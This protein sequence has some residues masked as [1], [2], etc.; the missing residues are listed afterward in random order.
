MNRLLLDIEPDGRTTVLVC[1][2]AGLPRSVGEP[3]RLVSPLTPADLEDLRWYLEDYLEIPVAGFE[4]R[5]SDIVARLLHWGQA[6]FQL[7]FGAGPARDAY[8]R[9]RERGAV[10]IVVR[11]LSPGWLGLPWELMT[12]P[13]RSTPLVLDGV[14]LSRSLPGADCDIALPV[15]GPRLRVLMVISRPAGSADVAYRMIAL[16]LLSRLV[17]VPGRVELVVLRP[18]TL[19]ALHSA[20]LA[21]RDAGRPFQ[22]VH[23][24]G[25]GALTGS[26]AE[27]PNVFASP[28]FGG[29]LLFEKPQG[30][31]DAVSADRL[32]HVLKEARVRVVVLNACE[33]G[34]VGREVEAA[35]ATRLL[36]D[37][38]AAVVA[39]AYSVYTKAAA[40]FM[41]AFYERLFAGDAVGEAVR[42]GR[43]RMASWPDRPCVVGDLPLKDWMVPVHYLR[44]EVRFPDLVTEVVPSRLSVEEV[45]DRLEART[46]GDRGDALVSGEE[47]VDRDVMIY[48]LEAA[49]RASPVVVLHGQGGAGKTELAKAFGRWWRDTAGVEKPEWVF[50]HSFE[51]GEHKLAAVLDPVGVEV[52]GPA[53]HSNDEAT[54]CALVV[55][56]LTRHRVLLI[57]DNFEVVAS[58]PAEEAGI[59]DERRAEFTEFLTRVHTGAGMV[60]IT[61]RSPEP[62]LPRAHRENLRG[63]TTSETAEYVNK[64]LKNSPAAARHRRHRS[65]VD[66]LAW[67]DGHPLSMRLI[68][69]HLATTDAKTLLARLR[70]VTPFPVGDEDGG[71]LDSLSVSITYSLR[72]L[73][74][75]TRRLLAAVTLFHGVVNVGMLEEFSRRP[76]VPD[77]FRSVDIR[78]WEKALDQAADVGLLIRIS[79]GLFRVHPALPAYLTAQWRGRD[80]GRFEA[81]RAAADKAIMSTYALFANK[82][83]VDIQSGNA[84]DAYR[85]LRWERPTM[86]H[87][88][89]LALDGGHWYEAR[90]IGRALDDYW[91]YQHLAAEADAWTDRVRLAVESPNGS[92]PPMDDPRAE[93]WLAF[94]IAYAH[95]MVGTGQTDTAGKI[96]TQ[97]VSLNESRSET[98]EGSEWLRIAYHGLGRIAITERREADAE[99]WQHRAIALGEK[100]EHPASSVA[101]LHHQLGLAVHHQGRLAEAERLYFKAAEATATAGDKPNLT[102]SYVQLS[103]IARERG[104]LAEAARWCVKALSN[105]DELGDKDGLAAAHHRL[106]MI[107]CDAGWWD[108]AEQQFRS[109]LAIRKQIGDLPG[110]VDTYHELGVLKDSEGDLNAARRWYEHALALKDRLG[111]KHAKASTYQQLSLLAIKQGRI[112]EADD[113]CHRSYALKEER[114]DRP[115]M[116][117]TH[118]VWAQVAEARGDL[119]TAMD[120]MVRYVAGT[121]QFENFADYELANLARLIQLLGQP[122]FDETWLDVTGAPVPADVLAQLRD[123]LQDDTK[124]NR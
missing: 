65:F 81:D 89:G 108:D 41:T 90:R 15:G 8:V 102:V 78:E 118:G 86:T 116:A 103:E 113:W 43:V 32:G 47:F 22:V 107:C 111:H 18:P 24:D 30:G 72:H 80:P 26:R 57:W 40:E 14:V 53:F 110:M 106:G 96:F 10:E 17:A 121:R 112:D 115:G 29:T 100:F 2:V 93:L 60:L 117:R 5:G 34:A 79:H 50:W 13:E 52:F 92:P 63:L 48:S 83:T 84:A 64:L 46:G 94:I 11:S 123:H 23:F 56:H 98:N 119:R 39:M 70:G 19:D 31:P 76:E 105:A 51:Q 71:R 35:V 27:A 88:F 99:R 122:A 95:R 77:H 68:L 75:R 58:M 124:E 37:G 36:S 20:L 73:A 21:A 3:V 38:A 16:P 55:D 59:D 25:H 104:Q 97:V 9:A 42:A 45:L 69:P 33:S 61:S 6:L 28:D 67:L 62:W 54:R 120:H 1:P 49:F 91:D 114:G 12:D 101:A 44:A 74:A 7:V 109:S 85:G 87:L 82:C 66:L 4:N